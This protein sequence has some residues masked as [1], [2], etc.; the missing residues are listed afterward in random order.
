MREGK[1]KRARV[2]AAEARASASAAAAGAISG[3]WLRKG[4][5][6]KV[7][8]KQ[9]KDYY[10]LKGS[11]VAIRDE[12]IAEVEMLDSGDILRIDQ[13][14]LETVAFLLHIVHLK[15]LIVSWQANMPVLAVEHCTAARQLGSLLKCKVEMGFALVVT[16]VMTPMT[17]F[18][19]WV[20]R[21][22]LKD[23]DAGQCFERFCHVYAVL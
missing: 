17:L 1:E 3:P 14:E 15:M 19:C 12:Y 11:V 6:V 7:M 21:S 20:V 10:K 9:L 5:V 23:L 16:P 8:A 4:I 18:S 2:Q 13:A 22:C